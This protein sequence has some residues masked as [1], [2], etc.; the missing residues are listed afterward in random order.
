MPAILEH[1]PLHTYSSPKQLFLQ[2]GALLFERPGPALRQDQVRDSLEGWPAG[3]TARASAED[4]E[5]FE[6]PGKEQLRGGEQTIVWRV[7]RA[8]TIR[9][10]RCEGGSDDSTIRDSA[11]WG[12]HANHGMLHV[13]RNFVLTLL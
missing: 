1:L 2:E 7:W 9:D 6:N 10:H 13:Q 3:A 4:I 8:T 5:R 12:R 11:F